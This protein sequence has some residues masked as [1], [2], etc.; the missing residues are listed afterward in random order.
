MKKS[1]E[2]D[3][4]KRAKECR[5]SA[6][7]ECQDFNE[8]AEREAVEEFEESETAK[9]FQENASYVT[10]LVLKRLEEAKNGAL[11]FPLRPYDAETIARLLSACTE[12]PYDA[13]DFDENL[14]D[15]ETIEAWES[16]DLV[17]DGFP[18]SAETPATQKQSDLREALK[19]YAT[20]AAT[21]AKHIGSA[22]LLEWA[23]MIDILDNRKRWLFSQLSQD[24]A[25]RVIELEKT[26][27][28]RLRLDKIAAELPPFKKPRAGKKVK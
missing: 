25:L 13:K 26:A 8:E 18:T 21:Y 9:Y 16:N 19:E 11:T 27:A 2:Q 10:G 14:S 12:A 15:E 1:E 4:H 22:S 5:M 3:L 6:A 24:K 20:A 28:N 7:D 17:N 23:E